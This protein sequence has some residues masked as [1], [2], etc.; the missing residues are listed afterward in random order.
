MTQH[1]TNNDT[2]YSSAFLLNH[3]YLYSDYQYNKSPEQNKA[4]TTGFTKNYYYPVLYKNY[5]QGTSNANC[6]NMNQYL[7]YTAHN[8]RLTKLSVN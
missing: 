3:M 2:R 1:K 4:K 7:V 5:S 8:K 6:K